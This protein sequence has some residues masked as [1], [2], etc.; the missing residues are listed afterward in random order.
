MV[1]EER[2][3]GREGRCMECERERGRERAMVRER[4]IKRER[5]KERAVG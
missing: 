4:W 5:A 1:R 3:G 2:D